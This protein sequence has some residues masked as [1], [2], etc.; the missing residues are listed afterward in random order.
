MMSNSKLS[1][2]SRRALLRSDVLV[3]KLEFHMPT[4]V[5][6]KISTGQQSLA[7]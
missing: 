6:T 7:I 3:D 4:R 5:N 1:L 2:G